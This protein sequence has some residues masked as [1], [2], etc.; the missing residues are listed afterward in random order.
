MEKTLEILIADDDQE[1]IDLLCE[2]LAQV[3]FRSRVETVT[4]GR[5]LVGR[6]ETGTKP[7]LIFLDINMPQKNGIECL[8]EIGLNSELS[9]IPVIIQS[10]SSNDRDID[11]CYELGARVYIVKPAL[12]QSLIL[13]V[14]NLLWKIQNGL[15]DQRAKAEFVLRESKAAEQR[16]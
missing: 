14:R 13:I 4:T 3:P 6:L 10:G 15:L 16:K 12:P 11:Q 1:D 8:R 9:K 7:D 2:A 5:E